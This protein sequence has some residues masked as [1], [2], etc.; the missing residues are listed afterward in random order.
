MDVAA[1]AALGLQMIEARPTEPA[2]AYTPG[3]E[4][5][6][7]RLYRASYHRLLYAL[8]AVTGDYEAAEDCVQEAFVKAYH[9]WPMW[10]PDAPA[11]AWLHRIGLNVAFSY[12]RWRK[13]R[14]LPEIV[15]RLGRQTR[16][17]DPEDIALRGELLAALRKLP[18][19]QAAAIVLRF[20]HG[21]TNRDMAHALGVPESTIASRVAAAKERLRH[22]LGEPA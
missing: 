5:D 13:L 3:S 20:H 17:T 7:D 6:F 10:K 11:E 18:P 22:E 4:A 14:E 9:A 19:E 1:E 12:L 16:E 8:L 2:P 15:R 21:Y